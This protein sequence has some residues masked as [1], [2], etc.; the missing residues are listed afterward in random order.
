MSK[1]NLKNQNNN[2]YHKK[3]K[4]LLDLIISE[5]NNQQNE[6]NDIKFEYLN[7]NQFDL[8]NLIYSDYL[9]VESENSVIIG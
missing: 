1:E 2:I 9:P 8:S 4:N 5:N 7:I 6:I 3:N